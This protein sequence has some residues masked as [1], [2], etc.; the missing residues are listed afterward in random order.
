MK[1]MLLLI[2]VF[3]TTTTFAQR[4]TTNS[5][6]EYQQLYGKKYTFIKTLLNVECK[7]EVSDKKINREYDNNGGADW[8]VIKVIKIPGGK[9]YML[10]EFGV[11]NPW[12]IIDQSGFIQLYE[13]NGQTLHK[14]KIIRK[15]PL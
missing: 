8:D 12:I 9:K 5:V 1:K 11:D 4:Y 13:E 6:S 2:A 15:E 14:F 7:W 10:N 3:I